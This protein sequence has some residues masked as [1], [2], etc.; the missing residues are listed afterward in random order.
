MHST[1]FL[2]LFFETFSSEEAFQSRNV[3]DNINEVCTNWLDTE[4]VPQNVVTFFS[5][6]DNKPLQQEVKQ[7]REKILCQKSLHRKRMWNGQANSNEISEKFVNISGFLPEQL[8][9]LLEALI[10]KAPELN[11]PHQNFI[12][13]VFKGQIDIKKVNADIQ[14]RWCELVILCGWKQDYVFVKEFLIE[15]QAMG[16]YLYNELAWNER[17]S[18]NQMVENI[19][20]EI[21]D[22]L[23]FST[24]QNVADIILQAKNK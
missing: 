1:D 7:A 2:R 14:H 19:F 5:D 23:D 3:S 22:E 16:I 17:K 9:M 24:Q 20:E 4:V 15:H 18:F 11:R 13:H 12:Y 6:V 21:K 10:E 8:I